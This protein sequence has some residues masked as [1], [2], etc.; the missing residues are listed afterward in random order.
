MTGMNQEGIAV[1][2]KK[3]A[4]DLFMPLTN[5]KNNTTKEMDKMT[6]YQVTNPLI[7]QRADPWI[8]KH[9]DGYYYF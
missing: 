9:S 2:Y 7:E 4:D 8:Y 3:R 1:W 5:E 6:K